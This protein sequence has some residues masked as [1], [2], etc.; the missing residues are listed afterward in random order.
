MFLEE[1]SPRRRIRNRDS[2]KEVPICLMTGLLKSKL[3]FLMFA[4]LVQ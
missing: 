1:S 3:K 4:K 2:D